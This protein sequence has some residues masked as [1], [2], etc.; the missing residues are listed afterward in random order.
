[1]KRLLPLFCLILAPPAMGQSVTLPA[2]LTVPK[3]G[4]VTITPTAFD[5]DSVAWIAMDDGLQ[6]IPSN[7]LKDD[8]TAVGVALQ[9]G[10]F[11]VR[12]IAAKVV[13]GKAAMSAPVECSITVGGVP[14]PPPGPPVP[15]PSPSPLTQAF[16]DAYTAEADAGKAQKLADLA[17][18]YG[19]AVN[20][21]KASG[22]ILNLS[23]FQSAIHAASDVIAGV[24]GMPQ[25]R[26]AVATYVAP[27]FPAYDI[28]ITP[29]MWTDLATAYGD[30]ATAL[31]GVKP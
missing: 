6:L 10:T 24:G 20:S 2:A 22:K 16:T 4:L 12:A 27:R 13:A 28:A 17:T 25:V 23:Q 3:A 5:A 31:K 15:P 21:Y 29:Q 1:M 11:R 18:L 7:L 30:V 26:K 8:K 19:T 14:P 9:P